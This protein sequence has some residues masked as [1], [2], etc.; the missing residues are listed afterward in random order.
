MQL[1]KRCAA[2]RNCAAPA[3]L[4]YGRLIAQ[5]HRR[6]LTSSATRRKDPLDDDDSFK[7]RYWMQTGPR[8]QDAV[9]VTEEKEEEVRQKLEK[10][11]GELRQLQSD[12]GPDAELEEL[13]AGMG[14]SELAKDAKTAQASEDPGVE[15]ISRD[16]QVN[17]ALPTTLRVYLRDFN[18]LV[19]SAAEELSDGSPKRETQRA[20]WLQYLR[21][22]RTVPS[23]TTQVPDAAWNVLWESQ[24]NLKSGSDERAKHLWAL[25]DDISACGKELLPAQRLIRIERLVAA[26][27][28][29]QALDLWGREKAELQREPDVSEAFQEL[30][31]RILVAAD[32]LEKA[33]AMALEAVKETGQANAEQLA[34]LVTA[35]ASKGDDTSLKIA[36]SLYLYMRQHKGKQITLEDFD[37]IILCFLDCQKLNLA[38]A[39]FKDMILCGTGSPFDSGDLIHQSRRLYGKLQKSSNG[40]ADLTSVSLTAIASMPRHLENRYLYASWMKRLIGMGNTQAA[41][42]VLQLMF[43]R[44]FRPDAKHVNGIMGAWL[45][46]EDTYLRD[47]AIQVG[48]TMVKERL[49]FVAQRRAVALREPVDIELP[50]PG[51]LV[52]PYI[53]RNLP[54]ATIETFSILLHHYERHDMQSTIQQIPAILE[55]AEIQPNAYFMNHLIYARLR[56]GD[57]HGAWTIFQQQTRTITPDLE[58]FAALW[59]CLKAHLGWRGIGTSPNFPLPRTLFSHMMSWHAGLPPRAQAAAR[60]EFSPDLYNQVLRCLCLGRDVEGTLVALHALRDTVRGFPDRST[61]RMVAVQLARLGEPTKTARQRRARVQESRQGQQKLDDV[62]KLLESITKRRDAA[63]RAAGRDPDGL[64]PEEAAEEGLYRVSILLRMIMRARD[65]AL[66]SDE[67]L[68]KRVE[69]VAF[70][71]GTGGLNMAQPLHSTVKQ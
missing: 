1:L 38:L 46:G 9:E 52:P 60:R 65:P 2:P 31:I 3:R 18:K 32:Q 61:V 5:S 67:A 40:L 57:T 53:S 39:V 16:L 63:I 43:E 24:Y 69:M 28:F 4:F 41:T 23:F 50:D 55:R 36:W 35:W 54:P 26:K 33:Q 49:K 15:D 47:L 59:D 58:S 48:W 37:R 10:L 13:Y 30:G 71:M 45:R 62:L 34:P 7:V 51:L 56:Q 21:C 19:G 64:R 29:E 25:V 20:L 12:M 44:G 6:P 66:S 70:E 42:Q 8:P 68:E 17:F 11:K 27:N 14:M 22:K